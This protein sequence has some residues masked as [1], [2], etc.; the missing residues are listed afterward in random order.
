MFNNNSIKHYN[1]YSIQNKNIS[2]LRT[3]TELGIVRPSRGRLVN[4][5]VIV[6][7]CGSSCGGDDA[8]TT[9]GFRPP[10]GLFLF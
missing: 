1:L 3:T 7:I 6:N 2:H 4:Y 9:T 8:Q 5:S 10:S